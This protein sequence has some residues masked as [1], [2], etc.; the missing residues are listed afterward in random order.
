MV[1]VLILP[2]CL[3]EGLN[4]DRDSVDSI[5]TIAETTADTILLG[6]TTTNSSATSIARAHSLM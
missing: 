6:S 2:D 5:M 3:P 4:R 1:V